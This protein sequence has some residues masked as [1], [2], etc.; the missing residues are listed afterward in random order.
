[1]SKDELA[2]AHLRTRTSPTHVHPHKT[3]KTAAPPPHSYRK[4][5]FSDFRGFM[6]VG[7]ACAGGVCGLKFSIALPP[8]P[9]LLLVVCSSDKCC[10]ARISV[11]R[12][13]VSVV[14]AVV[15][16]CLGWGGG[17]VSGA[18]VS[19][20]GWPVPGCP[21]RQLEG[22]QAACCV[23]GGV[24]IDEALGDARRA[25][26]ARWRGGGKRKPALSIPGS[27]CHAAKAG[28]GERK[29]GRGLPVTG[30]SRP[31]SI[32]GKGSRRGRTRTGDD[33]SSPI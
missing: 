27:R 7:R 20:R 13:A 21:V 15:A 9:R 1:M 11:D 10:G 28:A 33:G 24:L 6:C 5:N 29:G 14:G 32:R 22:P 12:V 18:G 25:P 31:G 17:R 30:P 3:P 4:K 23:E 26:R 2:P 8:L 19:A 16:R